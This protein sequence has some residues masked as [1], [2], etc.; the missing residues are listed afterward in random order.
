MA[1]EAFP[2]KNKN[3]V[4]QKF[5]V[6]MKKL[7]LMLFARVSTWKFQAASGS[8][9]TVSLPLFVSRRATADDSWR[10]WSMPPRTLQDRCL[11]SC[12]QW[13]RLS[14]QCLLLLLVTMILYGFCAF[15]CMKWLCISIF[16]CEKLS[17]CSTVLEPLR[18][19]HWENVGQDVCKWHKLR[20]GKRKSRI[21]MCVLI[22]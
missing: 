15:S 7:L 20:I 6:F 14:H 13:C 5:Q 11:A 1:G 17:F 9:L 21:R 22:W 16:L 8:R 19:M 10:H 12:C 18:N 2:V 3:P 4:N